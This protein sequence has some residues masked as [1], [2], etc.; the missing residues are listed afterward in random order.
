M[1]CAVLNY[2]MKMTQDIAEGIHVAYL[3]YQ[4]QTVMSNNILSYTLE[5]NQRAITR[6]A[7][8]GRF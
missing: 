8:H 2:T 3:N 7:T 5:K 1:L 6:K 4:L